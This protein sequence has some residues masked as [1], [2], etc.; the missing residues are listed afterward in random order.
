MFLSTISVLFLLF[1]LSNSGVSFRHNQPRSIRYRSPHI[2]R[3]I[4]IMEPKWHSI[5]LKLSS[6][7]QSIKRKYDENF[8]KMIGYPSPFRSTILLNLLS[9]YINS[10][11]N[12]LSNDS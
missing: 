6:N 3:E 5:R 1:S 8:L 2:I 11:L 7:D 4:R 9:D 12:T 10:K